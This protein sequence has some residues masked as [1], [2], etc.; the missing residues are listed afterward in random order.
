MRPPRPGPPHNDPAAAAVTIPREMLEVHLP[1]LVIWATDDT[2]LPPALLDGLDD[3]VPQMMLRR[4]G[5]AT[6]WIVHEQPELVASYLQQF[7]R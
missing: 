4:V 6:H 2:V 7:L 3:F 5:G 1:T